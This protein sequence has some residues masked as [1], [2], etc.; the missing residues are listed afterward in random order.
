MKLPETG[1]EEFEIFYRW[2]YYQSLYDK[3]LEQSKWPD[4]NDLT[5]VYLFA[6]M[7]FIPQLMNQSMDAIHTNSDR[8]GE[9]PGDIMWLWSKTTPDSPLRR[10]IIDKATWEADPE[11]SADIISVLPGE[12]KRELVTTIRKLFKNNKY[13]TCPLKIFTNYYVPEDSASID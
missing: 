7:A 5:R 12:G 3:D 4:I 2:V 13:V 10:F 6:D 8:T 11:L 9:L 1:V